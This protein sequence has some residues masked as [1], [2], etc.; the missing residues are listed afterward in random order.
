VDTDSERLIQQGLERLMADRSSIVVAHR[1][2]TVQRADRIL[3]L[4]KGRLEESGRHEELLARGGLYS[5]L[6]R[7]QFLDDPR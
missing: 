3:V 4:H 1:L 5:R 6:Y 7:L 2:T